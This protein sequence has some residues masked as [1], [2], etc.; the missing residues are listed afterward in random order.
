MKKLQ[1]KKNARDSGTFEQN[2]NRS[3]TMQKQMK[4]VGKPR[5]VSGKSALIGSDK[6]Q[7]VGTPKDEP[8]VNVNHVKSTKNTLKR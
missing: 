1:H 3:L 4:K 8:I 5:Q 6:M 2:H 7:K